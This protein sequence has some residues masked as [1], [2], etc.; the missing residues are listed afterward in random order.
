VNTIVTNLLV[1]NSLFII[2]LVLN[3]NDSS[4]DSLKSQNSSFLDNPVENITW[5]SLFFEFFCF[6][7]KIKNTS[8]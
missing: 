6:L 4:K 8:F 7:L 2:G 3:Q 1:L 5:L